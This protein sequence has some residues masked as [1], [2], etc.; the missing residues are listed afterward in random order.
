MIVLDTNVLSVLMHPKRPEPVTQWFKNQPAESL[1]ITSIT[2]F[3]ASFGI[4]QVDDAVRRNALR[5][6]F[7]A[8]LSNV[9]RGR[10]LSFDTAA[11]Y[12]A[13]TL[14]AERRRRSR[15]VELRDT[16]IAGIVRAHKATLA[17][18]NTRDFVDAGVPLVDPWKDGAD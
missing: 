4:E 16:Q 8:A 13:A 18:R 6:A 5:T 2:I 10:I 12:E 15:T 9:V 7:E 3:E 11:A 17:T 1:W 14:V